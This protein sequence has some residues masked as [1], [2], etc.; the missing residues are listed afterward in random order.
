M[1]YIQ[2][3]LV[4]RASFFSYCAV[5]LVIQLFCRYMLAPTKRSNVFFC[6]SSQAVD[7]NKKSFLPWMKDK[8]AK[9][10]VFVGK[11]AITKVKEVK[12]CLANNAFLKVIRN[13]GSI[14]PHI[15]K[16]AKRLGKSWTEFK[17]NMQWSFCWSFQNPDLAFVV[18]LHF[19]ALSALVLLASK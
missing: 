17:I 14:F 9:N 11:P 1:P 8:N 10:S 6:L 12:L 13:S 19:C 2:R 15:L 18:W 3:S 4:P 5:F 16:L 7:G